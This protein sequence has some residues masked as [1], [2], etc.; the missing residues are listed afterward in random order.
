[1]VRIGFG[2][3]VHRF[4]EGRRLFL[5]GVE[6]IHPV[7]L[8]GHSDADVLL[9]AVC[10]A[11]L[12]AAALRDIGHHFPNTDARWEGADSK[13]LLRAS[14]ELVRG[15]GYSLGNLDCTVVA[16]APKINPRI[17][18]MQAAMVA[19][20]PGVSEGQLSIKATTNEGIGFVGRGEG[21][22]AYAVCVLLAS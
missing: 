15:Q 9:H 21:I 20:M 8:L 10:D 16:E 18:E 17:A 5:G 13:E 6:F 2:Y 7:G 3:D 14:Y 1:M 11:L 4:A 22:A 12:G 19:V